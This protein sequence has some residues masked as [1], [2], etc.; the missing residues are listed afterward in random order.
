MSRSQPYYAAPILA[1]PAAQ[2]LRR[3]VGA[4]LIA[5]MVA[6]CGG[7][8]GDSAPAQS[9][10]P[11]PAPTP[12]PAPAEPQVTAIA[13]TS[14][15]L[16]A[17][18]SVT[19]T[20]LDAVAQAQLNGTPLAIAA[21]SATSLALDVPAGASSGFLTLVDRAGAV[22]QAAQ[23]LT[24]IA[25]LSVGSLAPASLLT[26]ATLTIGG[27]GLDRATV[28]EFSGGASATPGARTGTS[29]SVT[30][31]AGAQSGPVTVVAGSERAQSVT[32][33]TIVPRITVTNAITHA[34]AA[35]GSVTLSG[36]G[37]GEVSGVNVGTQAASITS[38][39]ATQLVFTVPAGTSCAGVTLLSASQPPVSGGSVAVGGG[40]TLRI[41]GIEFAQVMSQPSG[42]PRQRLVPRRETWVRAYVV[43]SATGLASPAVTLTAYSGATVLGNL[44]MTGPA[45]VPALADGAALPASL[46]YSQSQTWL[47]RLDDAWVGAGLRVE[48][49]ADGEQRYGAPITL[50]STPAVGTGTRID[51][52][53]VPL[54][55]GSNSP[56]VV[57]NAAA[58]ARDELTKRMPVPAASISVSVR[59]P[60]TLN[61][62]TDGVDTSAEWSSAL[63]ELEQL[64]DR[65]APSRHYYGLVQPMVSAGT[66]GIGYVNGIGSSS[67]ALA[68]LGWDTSRGSWLRTLVH[69]LG[70]NFSRSHAPCGSVSSSDPNY[71][72]AGGALGPTPLFDV[73]ADS[74]VL[75]TNQNDV[76][77]YC[78]GSWFSD[79][80]LAAVQRFLEARPQT[81]PMQAA[82]AADPAR[83]ATTGPTKTATDAHV[84]V[85][86]GSITLTG[87][88]LAPVQ[89]APGTADLATAGEYRLRLHTTAGAVIEVPFD[90]VMV[91]HALP[92]ERHFLVRVP[93]PGPLAGIE[94]LRGNGVVVQRMADRAT[95]ASAA[96]AGALPPAVT[97]VGGRLLLQWD[98][99]AHPVATLSHVGPE[100]RRVLALGA[101]G[102]RVE[103]GVDLPAGGHF[104]LALSDGLNTTLRV[105]SR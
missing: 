74:L 31:P 3:T 13:P 60:Y 84:V 54:V 12:S 10:T 34:V 73:L 80:N 89:L 55:S 18:L 9:P 104:E 53:L 64:R 71:P 69:E 91:D 72:Y 79:Y 66:A 100:G 99:G 93:D 49:T 14:F 78:S 47:A 45:Q 7:G 68:S 2:R 57:A 65:E 17:R 87:A 37:F 16:P 30:V 25:P 63:S 52:V 40:C 22:R 105:L 43:S 50:A 8:G 24:V 15:T 44:T 88:E 58:L 11:G 96:A 29:M 6:G 102:G 48:V 95:R 23:P 33:L 82:A 20:A 56:T 46:R 75:P 76:M 39:T 51:L 36:S 70:H 32:A 61:S 83:A 28:V 19:G 101:R 38:R 1:L 5:L 21:Q 41:E 62:V 77:G 98:A 86:A 90:A 97:E 26:G 81:A 92:P 35:G 4:V 59:A 42:D 103:L 27:S 94:V 67:P 85:I